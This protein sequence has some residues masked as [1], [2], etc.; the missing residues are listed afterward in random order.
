[1]RVHTMADRAVF[2]DRDGTLVEPRNYPSRPED[3]VLY[4]GLATQLRR[5][6]EAGFL[7]VLVTNQ[8]GLAR[9]YFQPGDLDRMHNR[10]N[11]ALHKEDAALDAIYVCPHHPDG[12]VPELAVDCACR[13]PRPG[14]LVQAAADFNLDLSRSWLVGDI[15]DDI[16][17][18]NRAGCRTILVDLGTE[19]LPRQPLRRP[20][21]IGRTTIHAL[22]II[23]AVE[24]LGPPVDLDYL[25]PGWRPVSDI[26]ARINAETEHLRKDVQ[27]C[28]G[29]V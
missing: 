20:A 22:E 7:L 5:L 25:P 1:M 6:R 24:G 10:L 13:K 4:P 18:G 16:E 2:L 14:L 19:Q 28:L 12:T 11:A 21:Y 29:L 23:Q 15:L 27:R 17:A 8:S 26:A 9:G 3:L